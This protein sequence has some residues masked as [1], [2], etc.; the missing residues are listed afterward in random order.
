[1]NSIKTYKRG[2]ATKSLIIG[3]EALGNR[4][5]I[6]LTIKFD[7]GKSHGITIQFYISGL[8]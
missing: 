7:A 5:R 4:D 3:I 8:K 2:V 6:E 1:M